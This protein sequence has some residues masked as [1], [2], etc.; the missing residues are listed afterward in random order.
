MA[1]V[2][3]GT[4]AGGATTNA[5][6]LAF[7][8]LVACDKV[9]ESMG[10]E[11]SIM[12][13]KSKH[14]YS[15]SKKIG[16]TT[17]VFLR[18]NGFECFIKK[19]GLSVVRKPDEAF[20]TIEDGTISHVFIIE[21]KNQN[22]AGSVDL[23]LWASLLLREEYKYCFGDKIKVDYV[24]CLS[25][26]FKHQF[27][28]SRRYEILKEILSRPHNNIPFFFGEDESY[29]DDLFSFIGIVTKPLPVSDYIC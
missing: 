25:D 26:W 5:N 4:G 18:Q 24:L 20:V 29:F 14:G 1:V 9:L 27:K 23:K 19:Y 12:S 2:N 10:F 6:G 3:R 8:D 21:K 15:L 7:E 17:Y 11:K 13:K 22:T 28:V 16:N